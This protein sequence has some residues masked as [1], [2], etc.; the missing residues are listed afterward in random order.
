MELEGITLFLFYPL[1][2]INFPDPT[3]FWQFFTAN[4]FL[5]GF[6]QNVTKCGER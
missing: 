5:P 2:F 4:F 6:S 3:A 1:S